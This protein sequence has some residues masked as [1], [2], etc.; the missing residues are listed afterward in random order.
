LRPGTVV[1]FLL[2]PRVRLVLA[3]VAALVGV[4]IAAGQ[5]WTWGNQP[6]R[7][8]GN[9]GHTSIDFGGQW[10]MGRMVALGEG[11]HLYHRS[12]LRTALNAAY[13]RGDEDPN[14]KISDA[15]AVLMYLMGWDDPTAPATVGSCLAPLA[16]PDPLA[17]AVLLTCGRRAWTAERLRRVTAPEVGGAL[18]P[19]VHAVLYAPLGR[20]SP[21]V[22]YRT[23]Q[24]LNLALAFVNA[25]LIRRLAKGRVWLPVAVL[26]LLAFPGFGGAAN[27][28]QNPILSLTLLLLGWL[29]ITRDRPVLG[30]VCWGFLAFKPV[31][32]VAFLPALVLTARWRAAFAMGVTGVTLSALTLPFVGWRAWLEWLEVGR[33]AADL[34]AKSESWIFLSRDLSGLPRRWLLTFH[35]Y[36]SVAPPSRAA[37]ATGL[38]LTLWLGVVLWT[39]VVALEHNKAVRAAAGPPAAFVLLGAW[40]SCYHF[41]YYDAYLAALPAVLLLTEPARYFDVRFLPDD[42]RPPPPLPV[43]SA[44]Q[45]HRWLGM[46]VVLWLADAAVVVL[47]NPFVPVVLALTCLLANVGPLLD[48]RWRFPPFETFGLL[49][50]WWWCGQQVRR[51]GGPS[52]PQQVGEGCADVAAAHEALA[53]Q[54]GAHPG[55]PKPLDVGAGANPA[56]ADQADA[57]GHARG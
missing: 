40:L 21:R 36:I 17:A 10:I 33:L 20:L 3:W 6:A 31:W 25:W 16:A 18:Y 45:R 54:D 8:D 37:L 24:L 43:L 11:R 14:E 51:A 55:G 19:P 26:G 13:P 35:D 5:A 28:G 1:R 49:L 32:A 39:V 53:D 47:R 46:V 48:P 27:L 38:G 56:L 7:R 52:A 34:Y 4:A 41:M 9:H 44:G 42:N 12:H 2:R 57:G 15:E 23:M 22:A 30:G 29:L 50:L